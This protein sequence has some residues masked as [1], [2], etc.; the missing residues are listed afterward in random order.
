MLSRVYR[1]ASK[2]KPRISETERAA[3]ESGTVCLDREIFGGHVSQEYMNK[4]PANKFSDKEQA[5]MNNE[6]EQLCA[7]VDPYQEMQSR[8]L[9]DET[10]DYMKNNGFWGMIV[11]PEYGGSK[12]SAFTHSQ[13]IQ[14][15]AAHST[16]AAISVGVPNSLGPGELL[17]KYGTDEQKNYYLPR[18]AAGLEIPCFA[19]TGPTSGSDAANMLDT[20]TLISDNGEIK[21]KLNFNKRY[22]TLA[23]IATVVGVAFK[24][25]DPDGLMPELKKGITLALLPRDIEGLDIGKRHDPL[26]CSFFNGPVRGKNVVISLDQI[27]GGAEQAG[28]GWRMLMECLGEGRGI[29]LPASS[30]SGSKFLTATVGAYAHTRQQFKTPLSKMEGIQEK[31]ADMAAHTYTMVAGQH[32]MCSML[33]QGERPAVLTAVLKQQTTERARDVLDHAMDILGGMGIMRGPDNF[34]SN[35]YQAIPVAITVEGSNTLTRSLMIYGQGLTRSHPHLYDLVQA[36][37]QNLEEAFNEH[38]K[39]ILKHGSKNAGLSVAGL[40]PFSDPLDRLTACFALAADFSMTMGSAIKF[41]EMLSGRYAD[42]FSNLYLMHAM[43]WF[44]QKQEH[45]HQYAMEKLLHETE[46]S[47]KDLITNFPGPAKYVLKALTFPSGYGR[48]SKPS[49]KLTKKVAEATANPG[50]FQD[51]LQESIYVQPG[52]RAHKLLQFDGDHDKELI[53]VADFKAL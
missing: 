35:I 2:L 53:Q 19:L 12:V 44:D 51:F 28:N 47:F 16:T 13:V 1:F 50:P 20:G 10:W 45:V 18:L 42:I 40:N 32:L 29:T 43:K 8:N 37:E 48:Y 22:I 39:Q 24:L 49:D 14:K 11:K 52:S 21:V 46:E 26:G 15:I 23:P 7:T 27:I 36:L 6:V 34:I 30:V 3:L 41:K 17:Q 9:S 31:L 4:Y 38:F 33:D 25:E 5:F